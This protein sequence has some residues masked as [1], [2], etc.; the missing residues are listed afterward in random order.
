[1]HG[2]SDTREVVGRADD[3]PRDCREPMRNKLTVLEWAHPDGQVDTFRDQI[4]ACLREQEFDL[5]AGVLV[6]K[7][8]DG[9]GE[10]ALTN[11]GGSGQ[12]DEAGRFCRPFHH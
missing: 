8:V 1:M 3:E 11:G 7:G 2:G 6:D 5:Y 9:G 4:D 10:E 12:P